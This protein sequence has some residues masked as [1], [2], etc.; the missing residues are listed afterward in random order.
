M[1]VA[2]ESGSTGFRSDPML[3]ADKA[4]NKRDK[5]LVVITACI[6]HF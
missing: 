5:F 4:S 2:Q 6:T 3:R 1:G